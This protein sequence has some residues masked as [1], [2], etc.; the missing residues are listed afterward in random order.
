M[1]KNAGMVRFGPFEFDFPTRELRKGGTRLRVP[2]QSLEILAMLVEPPGVVVTRDA[3]RNRLWPNGTIVEFEHSVNAA[4]KRLREALSDS[5]DEPPL[6]RDA[7]A[8]VPVHRA[9]PSGPMGFRP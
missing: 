2:D 8:R 1:A 4:V 7:Q 3:I 5:A 9:S 6:Y